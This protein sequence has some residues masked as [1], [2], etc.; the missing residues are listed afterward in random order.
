MRSCEGCTKCCDGTL[1]GTAYG[2]TF[3]PGK[4]C[5]F[6]ILNQGCSIYTDRPD[7]QCTNYE[8]EW[9][10]NEDYPEELKPSLTDMVISDNG[11]EEGIHVTV[12]GDKFKP[13]H[14]EFVKNYAI[15]NKQKLSWYLNNELYTL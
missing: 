7:P 13:E 10:K 1:G 12:N 8:C 14:L 2:H 4:P 6:V 9:I 11:P 15:K 5:F 3:F